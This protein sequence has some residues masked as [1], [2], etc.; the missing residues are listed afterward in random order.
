MNM[1]GR[2][3][4]V[5]GG[6]GFLGRYVVQNLVRSGARIRVGVRDVE[7]ANFLKTLGEVGQI[8]CVY[9]N[10]TDPSSVRQVIDGADSVINL[11]GIISKSG[12][13]TFQSVHVDGAKNIAAAAKAEG[14]KNLV[15]VSSISANPQSKSEYARTKFAGEQAVLD[16]FPDAV[17]LRPGM[18]IGPEDQ[19]MNTFAKM[20]RFSPVLPVVGCPIV[21]KIKMVAGASSQW[22]IPVLE[23]CSMG[24]ANFQPIYVGDVADAIIKSLNNK[25]AQGKI[26]ELTGPITYSFKRLL[27]LMLEQ[28]GRNC[29]IVPAPI[30]LALMQAFFM[31]FIPGSI[32]SRDQV[33]LM[34]E[35]NVKSGEHPTIEDLG[36]TPKGIESVLPTYL[37]CY[38]PT[39]NQRVREI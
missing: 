9:T 35:G 10:I 24:G 14:V 8:H 13:N 33:W 37:R 12:K 17:I 18:L 19:F 3:V 32:V 7:A 4:S 5:I 36:I 22:R 1:Q 39:K 23:F 15:H 38:R 20:A 6:A 28:T 11:A 29:L 26:F 34:V 30:P 16:A 21:P 27:Q 2:L 31:E 25:A